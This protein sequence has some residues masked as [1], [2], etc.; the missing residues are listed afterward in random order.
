MS[1]SG[2]AV[3]VNKYIEI[4]TIDKENKNGKIL[5]ALQEKI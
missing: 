2:V 3:G 5:F 1:R 4:S